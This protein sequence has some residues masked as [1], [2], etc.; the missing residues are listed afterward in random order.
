VTMKG[1]PYHVEFVSWNT[2]V[3]EGK[4]INAIFD[5]LHYGS[6][7]GHASVAIAMPCN[8]ITEE[9]V[10]K[11]CRNI[12]LH[13]PKSLAA[14]HEDEKYIVDV[15]VYYTTIDGHVIHDRDAYQKANPNT[16]IVTHI[17]LSWVPGDYAPQ[18]DERDPFGGFWKR[19]FDL[20]TAEEDK[21]MEHEGHHVQARRGYEG[22]RQVELSEGQIEGTA[23]YITRG[24]HQILHHLTEDETNYYAMIPEHRDRV[25][26]LIPF[27]S[28]LPE[29]DRNNEMVTKTLE[30]LDAIHLSTGDINSKY[31]LF[32]QYRNANPLIDQLFKQY[33]DEVDVT[34]L[35]FWETYFETGMIAGRE[36]IFLL[37]DEWM[38]LRACDNENKMDH[39][40]PWVA[41][42]ER[43]EAELIRLAEN[44]DQVIS[45]GPH[46]S[47]E[48][49]LVRKLFELEKKENANLQF[50]QYFDNQLRANL[51]EYM[52]LRD[53]LKDR[54]RRHSQGM[55]ADSRVVLPIADI[56][57][58]GYQGHQE[59]LDVHRM[60]QH[61]P[62]LVADGE[63]YALK[64]KNCSDMTQA[65]GYHGAPP[66]L[67]EEFK[68]T[69]MGLAATPQQ[70]KNSAQSYANIIYDK[71]HVP[72]T[73]GRSKFHKYYIKQE[74]KI[75]IKSR[76]YFEL[77]QK[78]EAQDVVINEFLKCL[79]DTD[80]IKTLPAPLKK[81]L[82]SIRSGI[83]KDNSLTT[84]ELKNLNE[85]K[86]KEMILAF[87]NKQYQANIEADRQKIYKMINDN[88]GLY[89]SMREEGI[90]SDE[91][92]KAK[93]KALYPKIYTDFTFRKRKRIKDDFDNKGSL[94][95]RAC[96]TL[97]YD[98][99]LG[100]ANLTD[101]NFISIEAERAEMKS[102]QLK[103]GW[104]IFKLLQMRIAKNFIAT[105]ENVIDPWFELKFA[106]SQTRGL[107]DRYIG[108]DSSWERSAVNT[109]RF[110]YLGYAGL[111][112]AVLIA[113]R[114]SIS[115]ALQR[116]N[117][118]FRRNKSIAEAS[119]EQQRIDT[120]FQ[121]RIGKGPELIKERLR[122]MYLA[123]LSPIKRLFITKKKINLWVENEYIS[124]G[125]VYQK[126]LRDLDFPTDW[127][128]EGSELQSEIDRTAEEVQR[129]QAVQA[130]IKQDGIIHCVT[131]KQP[132]QAL[133]KFNA[134]LK[135]DK[136]PYFDKKSDEA[137]LHRVRRL[138]N[139]LL[140]QDEMLET[141]LG[142]KLIETLE[143][144]QR[145]SMMLLGTEL[146][147][148]DDS[149]TQYDPIRDDPIIPKDIL[150]S[151]DAP[152]IR[153]F[154]KQ[155]IENIKKDVIDDNGVL[156]NDTS[157]KQKIK[158]MLKAA[159]NKLSK[160]DVD[161]MSDKVIFSAI[162]YLG[163]A[164]YSDEYK[165]F[166]CFITDDMLQQIVPFNQT[167]FI[168]FLSGKFDLD[169]VEMIRA[170]NLIEN[171]YI[172]LTY[173]VLAN[174]SAY[175]LAQKFKKPDS[176]DIEELPISPA[177]L[178]S[179]P[180]ASVAEPQPEL[181]VEEVEAKKKTC[182][183]VRQE[184]YE[185]EK[186][187]MTG[188]QYVND[189]R[190][191]EDKSLLV[192]IDK[193]TYPSLSAL[194]K[195]IP[196]LQVASE[197]F[198]KQLKN[199]VDDGFSDTDQVENIFNTLCSNMVAYPAL[200]F[201]ALDELNIWGK[202]E[203]GKAILEKFAKKAE[204]KHLG[205]NDFLITPVQ[206]MPR[207]ALLYKELV[208]NTLQTDPMLVVYQR[209]QQLAAQFSAQANQA[210]GPPPPVSPSSA[211]PSKKQGKKS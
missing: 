207:Y 90:L 125:K 84:D 200:Y 86:I 160:L 103:M 6:N 178:H 205:L 73:S 80:Y 8:N 92:I 23:Q 65:L 129:V 88:T 59:G 46:K 190:T 210:M 168:A 53:R 47:A 68:R 164:T 135:A 39:Y 81:T 180:E 167:K 165:K 99:A 67:Q 98:N 17:Y 196:A 58:I 189:F 4:G 155:R 128:T 209:W 184:L 40:V 102:L 83:L 18:R 55:S 44:I 131:D 49:P 185:T 16:E 119:L 5:S 42:L 32:E 30:Q 157:K 20:Y 174:Q 115:K 89:L 21:Q 182:K 28:V 172:K 181:S 111:R 203:E 159:D 175:N 2:P 34:A 193:E 35:D 158:K 93:M 211:R 136:I 195:M 71:N 191:A 69:A 25:E 146:D 140:A 124:E 12:Q 106:R 91:A 61:I 31:T 104:G 169:L 201:K 26:I 97:I 24:I 37:N 170:N 206:R 186:S 151:R 149:Y 50:Q 199:G 173:D 153:A 96:H 150:E 110:F 107:I 7:L 75:G 118:F 85:S 54:I 66:H 204:H 70:S 122:L 51:Q 41:T 192:V 132:L 101:P 15:P 57:E 33:C 139:F 74:E 52:S 183:R 62:R 29:V 76:R 95:M 105:S 9:W 137:I 120:R 126:A 11:Y 134:A 78:A 82:S 114:R 56:E 179:V 48:Y 202:T 123:S 113:P 197:S 144:L 177:A 36:N 208:K 121:M 188:L 130:G 60:L 147:S 72:G 112:Q 13:K 38:Y 116:L 161:N 10:Q 3:G 138:D 87:A 154:L 1:V 194:L 117:S 77:E 63:G 198:A 176:V 109:L 171:L 14:K 166:E 64:Y 187:F 163:A 27:Y 133:E 162:R 100:T 142:D 79:K 94:F 127:H 152:S 143:Q 141:I 156:P 43:D 108:M 45:D 19:G 145:T 22:I 148:E